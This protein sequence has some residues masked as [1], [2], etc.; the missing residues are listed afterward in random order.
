MDEDELLRVHVRHPS[1]RSRRR[2]QPRLTN[3]A[4]ERWFQRVDGGAPGILRGAALESF[5]RHGKRRPR[6]RH[7]TRTYAEPGTTFVYAAD[8]PGVCAVLRGNVVVTVLTRAL[9][10]RSPW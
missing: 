4:V 10:R 5:L 8:Q 7:W 1:R 2:A 3:H 9:C 6:P